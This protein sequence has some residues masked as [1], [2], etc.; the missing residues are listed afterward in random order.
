MDDDIFNSVVNVPAVQPPQPPPQQPKQDIFDMG[1]GGV[2]FEPTPPPQPKQVNNDPFNL[3]SLEMGGGS[4][5]VQTAPVNNGGFGGD[6]LGFGISS[7][8]PQP[9]QV[10][11]QPPVNNLMGGSDLMG[12]GFTSNP[13]PPVAVNQGG[14]NFGQTNPPLQAPQPQNNNFGFNLLGGSQPVQQAPQPVSLPA[15]NTTAF[16][17]IVNNN[18]NKILAYDNT[19]LQI[20][21]DCIKEGP[22]STKLFTTY[23]N[24]TNNTIT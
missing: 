21:I 14:F 2:S 19:H 8:P 13:S 22:D 12:F 5:P 23:V 15:Q 3:L 9:P 7:P 17:P 11:A 6:L 16:Q 1:L 4:Q 24:K 20:W 18:P 10:V